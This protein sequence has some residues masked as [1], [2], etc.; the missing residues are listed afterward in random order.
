MYDTFNK[1]KIITCEHMCIEDD[2][3]FG[4]GKSSPNL[5]NKVTNTSKDYNKKMNHHA[6]EK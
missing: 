3:P 5:S 2:R 1:S 4:Q 6:S